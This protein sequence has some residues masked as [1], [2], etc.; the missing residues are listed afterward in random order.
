MTHMHLVFDVPEE[1]TLQRI[2]LGVILQHR[3]RASRI[4]GALVSKGFDPRVAIEARIPPGS[5][6]EYL[7]LDDAR[8]ARNDWPMKLVT[9]QVMDAAGTHLEM[10]IA[11]VYEM[12]HH[13]GIAVAHVADEQDRDVVVGILDSARPHLWPDE[14]VCIAE[15]WSM[16]PA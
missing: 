12:V 16:E 3:A 10:R 13:L 6:V 7:Q 11:A 15:L 2:G 8:R 4:T 5:R 14:V 1:W 9:L